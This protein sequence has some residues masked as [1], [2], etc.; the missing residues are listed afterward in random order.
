MALLVIFTMYYALGVLIFLF[1]CNKK[2]AKCWPTISIISIKLL[3]FTYIRILSIT[4]Y[5]FQTK[6]IITFLQ[7]AAKTCNNIQDRCSIFMILTPIIIIL[8]CKKIKQQNKKIRCMQKC[9]L[10]VTSICILKVWLGWKTN[11][12]T[13]WYEINNEYSYNH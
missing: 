5:L 12:L 3:L 1:L 2:V 4:I 9:H 11:F 8:N 6:V 10:Q 13:I 7:L